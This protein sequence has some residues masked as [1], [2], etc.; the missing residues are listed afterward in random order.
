[1]RR[2]KSRR[3]PENVIRAVPA[4]A[5]GGTGGRPNGKDVSFM[6][7][8]RWTGYGRVPHTASVRAISRSLPGGEPR[9]DAGLSGQ[10]SPRFNATQRGTAGR[11][12]G[13]RSS[14]LEN[15]RLLR[16]LAYP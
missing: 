9:A 15:A 13:G 5:G 2:R 3:S 7:I 6:I 4:A 8:A 16:R 1:M 10:A 11:T 14:A 12:P